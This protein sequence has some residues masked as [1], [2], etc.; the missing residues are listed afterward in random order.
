MNTRT[1]LAVLVAWSGLVPLMP[2]FAA[3]KAGAY[4]V[5]DELTTYSPWTIDTVGSGL[6]ALSETQYPDAMSQILV[7]EVPTSVTPSG[8]RFGFS[9]ELFSDEYPV[10]SV[11]MIEL[12][13]DGRRIGEATGVQLAHQSVNS[14][15]YLF[16]FGFEG[17]CAALNALRR[18]SDIEVAITASDGDYGGL[19]TGRGSGAALRDLGHACP[20]TARPLGGTGP[21]QEPF[22]QRL[23]SS[24]E[25][26]IDSFIA[27]LEVNLDRPVVLNLAV[28]A[29]EDFGRSIRAYEDQGR[30]V[31]STAGAEILVESGYTR[32][33]DEFILT[34]SFVPRLG[35]Y[36]QGITSYLLDFSG[37]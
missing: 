25:A 2:G 17:D 15:T 22:T 24:D 32:R 6:L 5:D 10:P 19:F 30:L 1:M 8:M 18:G 34:G 33:G 21:R 29:G 23:A 20:D 37:R 4:P 14:W 27:A 13:V 28:E 35:G 26:G 9:T 12:L 36:T 16:G 11:T 3:E 31:I 7:I